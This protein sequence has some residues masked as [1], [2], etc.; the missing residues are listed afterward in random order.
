MPE[1]FINRIATAI[2][3]HDVHDAFL[4]FGRLML[5]RTTARLALFDRMAE[6]SGIAHRYSYSP[7]AAGQGTAVDADGFY[8]MGAFSRHRRRG[9]AS[10]R[11]CAPG[12][13]VEAVEKLLAGEDR[14]A[15][16][17]SDRHQLHRLFR[18]RHRPGS[19]WSA[20]ACNPDV[21]RTMV[22]FMGCYAAINALEAGAPYRAQRAR[23]AGAGGQSGALHPASARD[24]RPGGN[25]VLPA[26]RRWLRR[27]AGHRRSRRRRRWKSFHAA[28]VPDT[29]ELIRWHIREQG[30]DMVLSGGG[31]RRHPHRADRRAR[32][33]PGRRQRH[34]SV[35]GASGRAH[36]AG[37]GGRGLC[38]AAGGAGGLARRCCTITATCRRAR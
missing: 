20:A 34:R 15:H 11:A 32:R 19:W 24:R 33:H 37:C 1:A 8:R 31:A 6:R 3:P 25:S 13:A 17:P 2:P 38:P 10:S 7:A 9:C 14:A 23:G 22:G 5:G 36:R 21:E 29:R 35:G 16:H 4:G 30:F 18:A 27:G 12:L 28:L 26:V